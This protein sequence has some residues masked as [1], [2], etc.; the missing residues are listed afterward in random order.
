[1]GLLESQSS[2]VRI[3]SSITIGLI[4]DILQ[5]GFADSFSSLTHGTEN[6]DVDSFAKESSEVLFVIYVPTLKRQVSQLLGEV[7][8]R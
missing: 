7:L 8:R 1:M 5:R 4:R 3:V 2:G 6:A